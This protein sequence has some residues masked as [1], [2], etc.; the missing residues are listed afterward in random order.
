M[1]RIVVGYPPKA[2][3]P[4][5]IFDLPLGMRLP[6]GVALSVDGNQPVTFPVQLCVRQGCRADLP[7]KSSL[8]KQLRAGHTAKVT[9]HDPR[10]RPMTLDISLMGFT[11]ALDQVSPSP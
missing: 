9:I 3:G 7:L 10:G 4:I 8:L 1:M 2:P 11:N 5:A 6:P